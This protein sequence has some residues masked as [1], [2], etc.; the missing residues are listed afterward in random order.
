MSA[1]RRS[2]R[3]GR[4]HIAGTSRSS[5]DATSSA[6]TAWCLI[7]AARSGAGLR[8]PF[9]KKLG[10]WPTWGIR[11]FSYWGKTLTLIAILMERK[12]LL[13]CWRLLLR[14]RGFGGYGLLLLILGI[15]DAILSTLLMRCRRSAIMCICRSRADLLGCWMPC[16]GFILG[17]SIWSVSP[18]FRGRG[19]TYL[20]L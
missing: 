4:I 12:A 2:L 1:S 20:L 17:T 9:L 3:L 16:S 11:R 14:S 6:L 18:G 10:R 8:R 5:R 7:R 13:S 15:L 19:A